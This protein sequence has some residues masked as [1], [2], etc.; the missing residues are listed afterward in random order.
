MNI[1][2]RLMKGIINEY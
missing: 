2:K 1:N